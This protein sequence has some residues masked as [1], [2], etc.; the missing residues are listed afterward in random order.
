MKDDMRWKE[1]ETNDGYT[2]IE[3]SNWKHFHDFIYEEMLDFESYIWRGQ[4]RDDWELKST[5][6]RHVTTESHQEHLKRF[7]FATRGR[8]GVNPPAITEEKDWWALG[9]HY[10]LETPLLDWTQSPFVAAYFAFIGVGSKQTD[11]RAIY[12]LQRV[13][14]K[15]KAHQLRKEEFRV[16]LKNEQELE[17]KG[18]PYSPVEFEDIRPQVEFIR[19]LS[20]ENHRLV[21]QGGLFSRAPDHTTL[22]KWVRTNFPGEDDSV[23][24]K[25]RVPN[26]DREDSLRSLNRMNINHLTLFPDLHGASEFCNLFRQIENY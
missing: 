26:K 6:D 24:I 15:D 25:I 23:L 13:S 19:P 10:G 17:A 3:L 22:E 5:L 7:K 1:P 18:Q 21:N 8:R 20:D 12:A 4:R 11:S 16:A 14:V 9:Q 2:E